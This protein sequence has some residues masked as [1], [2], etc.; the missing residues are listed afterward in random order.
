VAGSDKDGGAMI[1]QAV[2]FRQAYIYAHK[3]LRVS[4]KGLKPIN[5]STETFFAHP[6]KLFLVESSI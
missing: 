3:S 2:G 1:Q 6:E 5:F 4:N